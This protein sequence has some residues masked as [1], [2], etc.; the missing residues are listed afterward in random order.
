MVCDLT[1]WEHKRPPHGKVAIDPA[2]GRILLPKSNIG[3]GNSNNKVHVSY[4]YGFS[5]EVGGGF[6]YRRTSLPESADNI[7]IEI[8]KNNKKM[9]TL[10]QAINEWNS[11]GHS[12]PESSTIFEIMDSEVYNDD[13]E[14]PIELNL[15]S[16]STLEIRSSQ[17]QRPVLK[18]NNP[19]TVTGE[20]NS[21]LIL[22]GILLYNSKETDN[23][24]DDNNNNN[25]L[26]NIGQGDL[27]SLIIRHCTLVPRRNHDDDIYNSLQMDGR[28][29]DL[30]ITLDHTII[31]RINITESEA[32]L[33]IIDTIV[34]GKGTEDAL[35]CYRAIIENS[36]I[37]GKVNVN[38]LELA[39]N[40]IFTDKIIAKRRQL[41]CV[42]FCHI[43]KGSQVPRSYRCQ[44]DYS[45]SSSSSNTTTNT[46]QTT[47]TMTPVTTST[48]E[49]KMR[50]IFT[51]ERYGEPGYA[52]LHKDTPPEIFEGADNRAE[53]G[54]FNHLY[55]PQR[56]SNLKSSINENIRL[57][58][59]VG[60]FLV[61]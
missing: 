26:I 1:D 33:K 35:N 17:G 32:Q 60:I 9:N 30:V 4:Y 15:Q 37:F 36:T 14:E 28:N 47:P 53:M 13:D 6:Y 34:D 41:G 42:R 49:W 39:S 40:T 8:S 52:Q 51:S 7:I 2:L 29:N 3:E 56:I 19:I 57:G 48:S 54:V 31:G 10:N 45:S 44:P 21:R 16:K 18:L 46:P 27:Q 5:S 12:K 25:S 22:D 20:K 24:D 55:Q 58:L 61:T 50:P 59:E 43:P 11:Q 38:I 23:D